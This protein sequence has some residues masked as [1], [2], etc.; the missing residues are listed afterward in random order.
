MKRIATDMKAFDCILLAA[1][2]AL[3]AT[4][5][6]AQEK[7]TSAEVGVAAA[8]DLSTA[9]K[10]IGDSYKKKTGVR[11]KLSFGASGALTQQIQNGAP[12]DLFF[13]A[14]MDYPRQLVAAGE[15]DG[16]SLHQYA[17]GK[18]VLWVPADSP[19]DVV[20]QGMNVL[21]DA[22]VNKIA[23]ANPQHAPYGRA[24]VAALKHA[25]V[26]DQLANRLVLGENVAQAAQFVESGNAQAGFVALAHAVAPG[27][28][29]KGK[30]WEVPADAY[31]LLAQGVVVLSQSQHK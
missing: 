14:D 23:I 5:S 25:G 31:P 4:W 28:R 7:K 15:A 9:L 16:R 24:A 6:G 29:G 30:Y 13:S 2:I 19:L 18:L 11:V 21:L 1:C 26:Y 22:S 3:C 12:F 17:V 20:C 10:E 27:M 8:A